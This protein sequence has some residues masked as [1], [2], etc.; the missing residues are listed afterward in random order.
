MGISLT[1]DENVCCGS[2]GRKFDAKAG[3]KR[4]GPDMWSTHDWGCRH[5]ETFTCPKCRDKTQRGEIP[6]PK[7]PTCGTSY[8]YT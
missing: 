8:E 2:C 4:S 7:C 3:D 1:P 5:G 6:Y